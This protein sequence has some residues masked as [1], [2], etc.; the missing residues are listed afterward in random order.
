M[1][2]DAATFLI[3][4]LK[5]IQIILNLEYSLL[6]LDECSE[7]SF[8][9]QTE[10]FRLFKTIR[11]ATTGLASK[12]ACAFFIGTVYPKGETYYPTRQQDGFSF[13]I[14][15]DCTMEFLQWDETDLDSY[16]SFFESMTLNRA[17][18]VLGFQ[19]KFSDLCD[20]LFENKK[21]FSL[22]AYCAHGI[23]RRYWEIVKRSY[24]HNA[25]KVLFAQVEISIQEIANEQILGHD[26]INV[27]DSDFIYALIRS[28]KKQNQRPKTKSGQKKSRT[29]VQNLYFS[30]NRKYTDNLRRLVMQ[31]AVHEKSRMRTMRKAFLRPQPVY[32]LDMAIAYTF[33]A[34]QNSNYVSTI[35]KDLPLCRENDF[36]KAVVI[37][38]RGI[39][40][41]YSRESATTKEEY[42]E[43][44]DDT[45]AEEGQS[46]EI[47]TG[48]VIMYSR[49]KSGKIQADDGGLDALFQDNNIRRGAIKVGDKVRFT[50]RWTKGG[51]RIALQIE[52]VTLPK[53]T[54]GV[55]KSYEQGTYGSIEVF[56]GGP[57]AFFTARTL[58]SNLIYEL[59]PGDRVRFTVIETRLGR[60]AENI[61][62]QTTTEANKAAKVPDELSGYI[63]NYIKSSPN[64]V[65]MAKVAHQVRN[66]FG[67]NVSNTQ[68]FGYGTFKNLLSQLDLGDLDISPIGPSYLFDPTIHT[69]TPTIETSTPEVKESPDEL[70]SNY[71]L[72]APIARKVHQVG[73]PYLTPVQYR[74]LFEELAEAIN[75]DGYSIPNQTAKTVRDRCNNRGYPIARSNI[76]FVIFGY[77]FVSHHLGAQAEDHKTLATLFVQNIFNICKSKNIV[78]THDEEEMIKKWIS[79][80]NSN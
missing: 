38:A 77:S 68:W 71:P 46:G 61:S 62:L 15:Q 54:D 72:I 55:V 75:E 35:T 41:I 7:A 58:S 34:I 69:I 9:A 10:I 31:G 36:Q 73:V 21:A 45:E 64:P 8:S 25:E 59:K 33:Q 39:E 30:I 80:N 53:T 56:D 22:A 52:K 50:N 13:E 42:I 14:G 1:H 17:K 2:K 32:A 57:D 4:F 78:I 37:S 44:V 65:S 49:G 12:D 19:G 43:I 5:Q 16:L 40:K 70:K 18:E 11:G 27:H 66:Y 23:P 20:L 60:Q 76:A 28:L 51:K 48:N 29:D 79:G 3:E 26:S 47:S 74:T 67:D 24:D 63:V 6:L